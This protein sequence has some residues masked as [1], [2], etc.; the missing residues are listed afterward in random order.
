M[1]KN[2]LELLPNEIQDEIFN[3]VGYQDDFNKVLNEL[4][5]V[6][7]INKMMITN[8]YIKKIIIHHYVIYDDD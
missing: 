3:F 2:I 6:F 7:K 5:M 8:N 4:K 1:S